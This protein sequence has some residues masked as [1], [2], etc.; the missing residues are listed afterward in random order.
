MVG[1][2]SI[3]AGEGKVG[4][5]GVYG[6]GA[7]DVK[8]WLGANPTI[9][10]IKL[11]LR[12][13]MMDDS[14]VI[15]TGSEVIEVS[16]IDLRGGCKIRRE[17]HE[18]GICL[19]FNVALPN[20]LA[21]SAELIIK[22]FK[23]RH[24]YSILRRGSKVDPT[25]F[26]AYRA[27]KMLMEDCF[28]QPG[29]TTEDKD[30]L[31]KGLTEL[32][33]NCLLLEPSDLVKFFPE[34]ATLIAIDLME[35]PVDSIAK[36]MKK[37][38]GKLLMHFLVVL[39]FEGGISIVVEKVKRPCYNKNV[40]IGR[41]VGLEE[42]TLRTSIQLI[43][44]EVEVSKLEDLMKTLDTEYK[45]L[46]SNCWGFASDFAKAVVE[47]LIPNVATDNA[48]KDNLNRGLESL[49]KVERPSPCMCF[50]LFSCWA[51]FDDKN[52]DTH[53]RLENRL[54]DHLKICPNCHCRKQLMEFLKMVR[55]TDATGILMDFND[56]FFH[57]DL[58][59]SLNFIRM[60]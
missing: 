48:D 60:C 2:D 6:M 25:K 36:I 55:S 31:R 52:N 16:D 24:K 26:G 38:P 9:T 20:G 10:N 8:G 4:D 22:C 58:S 54:E 35:R 23:T 13:K 45:F 12:Q 18:N 37:P 28:D 40:G 29:I 32:A 59:E 34:R 42:I 47:L 53:R 41:L 33:D 14:V 27:V 57:P 56:V 43:G 17:A 5:M 39:K 46:S 1:I 7:S 49:I 44:V 51:V 11:K 30:A 50:R 3:G 21:V 15:T 19:E